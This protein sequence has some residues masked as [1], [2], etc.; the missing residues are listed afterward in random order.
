MQSSPVHVLSGGDGAHR[1]LL[2]PASKSGRFAQS[3][4]SH[5]ADRGA[6]GRQRRPSHALPPGG[7]RSHRA[8]LQ[9]GSKS[10]TTREHSASVQLVG[11]GE[12]GRQ[13]RPMHAAGGD[14]AHSAPLH[15]G[16]K[17]G[18]FVQIAS[19]QLIVSKMDTRGAQSA[20]WQTPL[21][22]ALTA[23]G[24]QSAESQAWACSDGGEGGRQSNPVHAVSCGAT[25]HSALLHPGP[26]SG[27]F[28]HMEAVHVA[29]VCSL[30]PD[31]KQMAVADR[32]PP[33]GQVEAVA[34]D[35]DVALD[36][37]TSDIEAAIITRSS[38]GIISVGAH[39]FGPAA[40]FGSSRCRRQTLRFRCHRFY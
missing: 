31:M 6:E 39:S 37:A 29:D 27:F 4:S 8:L 2:H 17:S 10:G 23:R 34:L 5:S 12:G 22:S 28:S 35:A 19:V 11:G 15:P 7:A 33:A 16:S 32:L 24:A 9:P 25:V 13:R 1:A 38:A 14:G 20:P 3:P 30:K 18:P 40:V 21:A 26:K 36:A